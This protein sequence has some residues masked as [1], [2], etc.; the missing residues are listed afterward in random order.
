MTRRILWFTTAYTVVIIVHEAAH[1]LTSSAFGFET[2]LYHFW[3]DIDAD[4]GTMSQ[5]AAFGVAGPVSG[6]V[7]GF[8]ALIAYRNVTQSAGALPLL[9]LAAIGISNFFGNLMSA[10]FLGDFSN[11]AIWLNLPM[12]IRYGLSA[13]GVIGLSV[14]LFVAGRELARWRPPGAG[15]P[16]AA[17]RVVV[18]PV[19]IG[20]AIIVLINQ[21]VP[22]PGFAAA[23]AGEAAFWVF[24]V[25]GLLTAR[26]GSADDPMTSRVR[27][28]EGAT[29]ALVVVAVR[30]MALGIAL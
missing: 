5:R 6:L 14:T 12:A 28:Q 18:L 21:P 15:R 16:N 9:Y 30:V 7:I 19:V 3:V 17:L 13:L 10:S 2:T 23:R 11:V 29:A 24:A 22:I 1:A 26:R 25:A 8:A 4:G 20:T 27:W